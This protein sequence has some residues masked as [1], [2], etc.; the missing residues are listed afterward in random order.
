MLVLLNAHS[1]KVP[2]TLPSLDE[3]ALENQDASTHGSAPE[4]NGHAPEG[5]APE[6]GGDAANGKTREPHQ[7]RRMLDTMASKSAG[8]LFRGGVRYP[9]QGRSLAVFK[10]TPPVRE[11]RRPQAPFRAAPA[12]LKA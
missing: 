6:E 4:E 1:E 9:L 11:R 10:L 12:L 3:P 8:R 7:W 2:F 5:Q